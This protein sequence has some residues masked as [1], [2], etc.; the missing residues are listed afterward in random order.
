M[1]IRGTMD[2]ADD[3]R[4]PDHLWIEWH[5]IYRFTIDV[6]ASK[7][8]AKLPRY[9]DEEADGLSQ[10]W[11]EESVW[12]NPPYSDIGAWVEKS[13]REMAKGCRRVVMLIPANRTEQDWWHE[14][15]EPYRDGRGAVNGTTVRVK[16]VRRRIAFDYP[17]HRPQPR[18]PMFGCCLLIWEPRA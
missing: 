1:R 17:K 8:N 7:E 15:I 11:Y 10:S 2:E 4:T 12:C 18:S 3:R 16:F 13:W 14:H 9:Y 5:S 6:A